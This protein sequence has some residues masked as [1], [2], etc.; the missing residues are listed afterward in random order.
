ME[1]VVAKKV[2]ELGEWYHRIDLGEGVIT[3][4]GMDQELTYNLYEGLL[5]ND[6]S[7][8]TVLDLGANACG[9]SIEFAKRGAQV[10]AVELDPKFIEQAKFVVDHFD[11]SHRVKIRQ[12]D[13]FDAVE[14][15]E[16]DIVAYVGLSYHI[17]YPQ[18]ALDMLSS[19]CG[20]MLVASTQTIPGSGLSMTNRSERSGGQYLSG[21]EPTEALFLRMISA[22]G[23]KKPQ[24]VS[25][26][27]HKGEG[28]MRH[29]GNRSYFFARAGTKTPLPFSGDR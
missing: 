27:P 25:T 2:K 7:G 17:R 20:Q 1:S 13:L 12:G 28:R 19:N 6:L 10:L 21:Y 14:L 24:L 18:L 9:F 8:M 26:A 16:F 29:C 3:P 4:G 22:A 23:F 11:L 5:P 15:G